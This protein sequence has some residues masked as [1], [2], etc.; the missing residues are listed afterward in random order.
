MQ[1]KW[2]C[3]W[4]GKNLLIDDKDLHLN[5]V[6]DRMASAYYAKCDGPMCKNRRLRRMN[7]TGN[8]SQKIHDDRYKKLKTVVD[9]KVAS[10][11]TS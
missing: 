6:D 9:P 3:N 7:P 11:T 5:Q 8:G 10:N 4:C 2:Q 1:N